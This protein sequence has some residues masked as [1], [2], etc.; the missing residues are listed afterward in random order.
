MAFQ[1]IQDKKKFR[2][3]LFFGLIVTAVVVAN[4]GIAKLNSL[5]NQASNHERLLHR[6]Q[7]SANRHRFK[8]KSERTRIEII[9]D[10]GELPAVECYPGKLNQVFMNIIANA[11]D[12][13]EEIDNKQ[14]HQNVKSD[15]NQII[16]RTS[17]YNLNWVEISIADN[18]IG[19]A[20]E[21][22]Q[23]IFNPFFTTK[24]I[25]KGTGLGM[26]ISYQIITQQ[27]NGKL[28][29]LSKLGEGREFI[30]QIPIH[31]PL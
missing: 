20:K 4:L 10:Y 1:I 15:R 6:L 28:M 30:I 12:A 26:S 19:I 18:G 23:K 11:I 3:C 29:C 5:S 27:H 17:I 21:F 9:R 25:G 24:P 8:D 13:L 7:T 14:A 2:E 16:I 31:Q 22:Q